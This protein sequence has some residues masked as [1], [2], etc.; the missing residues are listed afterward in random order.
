MKKILLFLV[1]LIA[2]TL[3]AQY[4]QEVGKKMEQLP[5]AQE[6][7]IST[8]AT[9]INNQFSS[10]DDKIAAVFYWTAHA[11][12]YDLPGS[13]SGQ[14]DTQTS[15]DKVQSA[16]ST[17]KGVCMHYAEVFKALAVACGIPTELVSG[18][19]KQYGKISTQ[20]HQWCAAKING[21]WELFDP[22]WGSG[23]V[24][25]NQYQEKFDPYYFRT[26]PANLIQSHYPFEYLW[27]LAVNPLS[28]EQFKRNEIGSQ[29]YKI[30]CNPAGEIAAYLAL[31]EVEKSKLTLNHLQLMGLINGMLRT[32]ETFLKREISYFGLN[33]TSDKLSQLVDDF[34]ASI[35][36]YNK[37]VVFRNTQFK[38]A[39][40]DEELLSSVQL[41]YNN[42]TQAYASLL[43]LKEVDRAL[44]GEVNGLKKSFAST[45]K[46]WEVQVAFVQLYVATAVQ[47]REQ[48]FYKTT[49]GR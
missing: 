27:Q 45:K 49:G 1:F 43:A 8:I 20:T 46:A 26:P 42:F 23:V 7:S 11:I 28:P 33:S 4:M 22:T 15:A 10:D 41:P 14:Y 34:N 38:P 37:I 5:K 25:E 44:V 13:T 36:A 3:Q 19:T 39:I 17:R 32:E 16:L 40:S 21:N 30:T 2:G 18:Y 12:R 9:Y 24:V 29:G 6:Q 31:S 35:S 48:L 47:N